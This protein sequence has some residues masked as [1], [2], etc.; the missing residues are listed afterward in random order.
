MG[1]GQARSTS[2]YCTE[3]AAAGITVLSLDLVALALAQSKFY[4]LRGRVAQHWLCFS[5]IMLVPGLP[6][7]SLGSVI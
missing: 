5:R 6:R 4:E 2:A 3:G 1:L 7:F